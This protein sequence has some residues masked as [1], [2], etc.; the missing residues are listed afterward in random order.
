MRMKNHVMIPLIKFHVMIPLIKKQIEYSVLES[1]FLF[2]H[3][4]KSEGW[5]LFNWNRQVF[6]EILTFDIIYSDSQISK[7]WMEDIIIFLWDV[8]DAYE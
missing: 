2:T 5:E 4:L 6:S 1:C 8:E 7:S 3:T